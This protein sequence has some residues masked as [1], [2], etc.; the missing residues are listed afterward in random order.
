MK[1]RIIPSII[2]LA[3]ALVTLFVILFTNGENADRFDRILV[4]V[5]FSLGLLVAIFHL[6]VVI[7]AAKKSSAERRANPEEYLK[8]FKLVTKEDLYHSLS[9]ALLHAGLGLMTIAAYITEG[10]WLQIALIAVFSLNALLQ[11]WILSSQTKKL[12]AQQSEP[13]APEAPSDTTE[14]PQ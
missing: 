1:K 3:I 2:F 11:F 7:I 6:I 4:I 14:N 13:T 9:T 10:N 12:K 5:A 8:T